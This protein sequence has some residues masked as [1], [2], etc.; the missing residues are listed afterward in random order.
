[1][2]KTKKP[3]SIQLTNREFSI[4]QKSPL[5]STRSSISTS[6]PI[7]STIT[8]STVST[9][10]S[11]NTR[12]VTS[13]SRS[14]VSTAQSNNTRSDTSSQSSVTQ[15][16]TSTTQLSRK[17]IIKTISPIAP[18]RSPI[19]S[20]SSP[21]TKEEYENSAMKRNRELENEN[22]QLWR[23]IDELRNI[24]RQQERTAMNLMDQ[25]NF[26]T[27][28]VGTLVCKVD[29]LH[30][31]YQPKD[32]DSLELVIAESS[33]N[34]L[35]KST[36]V[37]RTELNSVFKDDKERK[38][39]L[40]KQ[41]FFLLKE[42]GV[43]YDLDYNSTWSAQKDRLT[44][45]TIPV[46]IKVLGDRFNTNQHELTDILKRRHKS[47]RN[48]LLVRRDPFRNAKFNKRIHKNTRRTEVMILVFQYQKL[49]A[50]KCY[51]LYRNYN[52]L[53]HNSFIDFYT[54]FYFIL[55]EIENVA[56]HVSV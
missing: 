4:W 27:S 47:S 14:T 2:A 53:N 55:F 43:N 49:R 15:P 6:R 40:R 29:E 10:Q 54:L 35:R 3:S 23:E 44:K 25:I 1:M 33:T 9:A 50:K 28:T 18:S 22:Q 5:V 16:T 39:E 12:S 48:T 26:L 42:K 19:F 56:T 51:G 17:S 52:R 38:K 41:I 37:A 45:N 20:L 24:T 32:Q 36:S 7:T 21:I 30:A 34:A 8:K 11:N 13:T 46:L 31:L